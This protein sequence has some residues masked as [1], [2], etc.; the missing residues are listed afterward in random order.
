[1]YIAIQKLIDA[2]INFCA[3]CLHFSAFSGIRLKE[4]RRNHK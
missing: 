1:M 2:V 3:K 4:L